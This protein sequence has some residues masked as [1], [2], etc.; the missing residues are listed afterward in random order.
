M[1]VAGAHH[2]LVELLAQLHHPP[3]HLLDVLHGIHIPYPLG[4]YHEL[5]VARGLDLQIVIEVHYPGDLHVALAVQQGPVELPGLTGAPQYESLPVL[6]NQALGNPGVPTCV[7]GQVG[8][9]HQAVEVDA[10]QVVL[11]QNDGMVGG[12]FLHQIRA[13]GSQSV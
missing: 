10:A 4:L 6:L 5:I 11:G 7:I 13:G 12:R 2:G 3:V 9:R 8:L 1:H